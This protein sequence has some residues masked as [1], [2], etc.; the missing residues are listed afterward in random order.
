MT[1]CAHRGNEAW[2]NV[3]PIGDRR[4][5]Y[6]VIDGK[7]QHAIDYLVGRVKIVTVN[8]R[9]KHTGRGIVGPYERWHVK[10][11]CDGVHLRS[12][13]VPDR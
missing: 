6:V 13:Q 11:L 2:I 12:E 1:P 9:R 5:I 3:K 8:V 4:L 10:G 7:R